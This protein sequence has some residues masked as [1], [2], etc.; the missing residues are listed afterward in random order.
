MWQHIA[1]RHEAGGLGGHRPG[2][3]RLETGQELEQ[4]RLAAAGRS[5]QRHDL[6]VRDRQRQPLERDEV[7]EAPRDVAQLGLRRPLRRK[8]LR[9]GS[10]ESLFHRSLRGHY[11]DRFEGSGPGACA[12]VL[13]QP[14]VPRAPLTCA[15]ES[16]AVQVEARTGR[17]SGAC[18][19]VSPRRGYED[20]HLR[21]ALGRAAGR[22]HA[23]VGADGAR[24]VRRAD[25]RRRQ[26][27][28]FGPQLGLGRL[29]AGRQQPEERDLQRRNARRHDLERLRKRLRLVRQPGGRRRDRQGR[30]GRQRLLLQPGV[31]R[32]YGARD[33]RQAGH[34]PRRLLLRHRRRRLAA[35]ADVRRAERR[36]ARQRRR[37]SR[38]CLRQLP[39]GRERGPDG[40]QRQ[41]RR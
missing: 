23:R 19:A 36:V 32:R 31:D 4:G 30:D 5:D 33:P 35:T 22:R 12:W 18:N 27:H 6:S 3:G 20:S 17:S 16:N 37:R 34:Q 11:P 13:S 7:A 15:N 9:S 24:R 28:L 1:L 14:A 29:Q 2:I 25:A 41:R 39:I 21:G 38:R 10:L 26:S 40:Q 8:R